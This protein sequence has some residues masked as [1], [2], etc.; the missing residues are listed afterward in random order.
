MKTPKCNSC[1]HHLEWKKIYTS[2]WFPQK[3]T[4]CSKCKS[5]HEITTPLFISILTIML[6]GQLALVIKNFLSLS[7]IFMGVVVLITSIFVLILLIS[8]FIP[9]FVKCS[10]V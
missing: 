2:L 9:Y 6:A 7:S 10:L 1:N 8:L 4:Q 5:N 3:S